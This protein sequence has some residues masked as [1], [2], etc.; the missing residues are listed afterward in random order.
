[1]FQRLK[2][3]ITMKEMQD[4]LGMSRYNTQKWIDRHELIPILKTPGKKLYSRGEF[5]K[6]CEADHITPN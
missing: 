4:A 3:T 6:A 1:M 2:A 5:V